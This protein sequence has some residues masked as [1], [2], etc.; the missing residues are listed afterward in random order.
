M[1]SGTRE[2]ARLA[3]KITAIDGVK[4]IIFASMDGSLLRTQ[5]IDSGPQ[6]AQLLALLGEALDQVG[7]AFG[8]D[9]LVHG[10]IEF[11]DHRILIHT[12]MNIYV[13]TKIA[14][15]SSASMIG[16]EVE[17]LLSEEP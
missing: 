16:S 17:K 13:G 14:F 4:G 2:V 5:D 6:M 15:D 1:G 10:S 7:E 12:Y 11:A 3:Q 9:K 8:K